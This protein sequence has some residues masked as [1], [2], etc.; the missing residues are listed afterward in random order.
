M[1]D[2][3]PNVLLIIFDQWS[4]SRLGVAGHPIVETPV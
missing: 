4:G 3:Q 2:T 1:A